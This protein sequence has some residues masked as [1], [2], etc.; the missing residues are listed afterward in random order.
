MDIHGESKIFKHVKKF[1]GCSTT[2]IVYL[3]TGITWESLGKWLA[4]DL[5]TSVANRGPLWPQ[6]CHSRV[7]RGGCPSIVS[8]LAQLVKCLENARLTSVADFRLP[9]ALEPCH[10]IALFN[11]TCGPPAEWLKDVCRSVVGS[12]ADITSGFS[13]TS[14]LFSCQAADGHPPIC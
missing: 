12:P 2:K 9:S 4:S 8:T 5:H 3:F 10:F 11:F 13:M 6:L 7:C 1:G 14:P